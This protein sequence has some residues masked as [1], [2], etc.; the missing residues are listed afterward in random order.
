MGTGTT[1]PNTETINCSTCRQEY[2]PECDYQQGRCPHHPP[3]INTL[4]TWLLVLAAPFIIIPWVIMNPRQ[5]WQQARK[6]WNIK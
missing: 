2:S 4:P 6:D 1:D 5:V 3:A